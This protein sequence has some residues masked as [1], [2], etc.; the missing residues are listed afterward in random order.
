[1]PSKAVCNSIICI[2]ISDFQYEYHTETL[3][4]APPPWSGVH[5][6]YFFFFSPAD[7]QR[8]SCPALVNWSLIMELMR[9]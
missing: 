7:F 9:V 2:V 6:P 1:M 3:R 5:V 8:F 4:V